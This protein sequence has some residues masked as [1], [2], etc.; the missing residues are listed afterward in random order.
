MVAGAASRCGEGGGWMGG[1]GP[2]GGGAEAD[3]RMLRDRYE[4]ARNALLSGRP[5]SRVDAVREEVYQA[6]VRAAASRPGVFRLAA[7]TGSG[8]TISAGGFA[9]HHAAA[10]SLRRVVVAVPFLTITEQNA[11]VYRDLLES[12]WG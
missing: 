1:T 2:G 8:K 12:S 4:R 11:Q 3:F 6:C 7:P 10:H 9:L 5:S